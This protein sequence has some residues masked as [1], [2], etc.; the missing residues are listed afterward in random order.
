MPGRGEATRVVGL[1]F[2]SFYTAGSAVREGRAGDLYKLDAVRRFQAVLEEREGIA[3]G[4]HYAPWWNP[5]FYALLFVPLAGMSFHLALWVWLIG[6]VVCGGIACWLLL[7]DAAGGGGVEVAGVGA[8]VN[9]AVDAVHAE[10]DARA[11]L[12]YVIVDSDGGCMVLAG[13]AG[14]AGRDGGGTFV[15]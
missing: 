3:I 4:K 8:G 11:E 6:N 12:V 2:V 10:H 5:P 9:G 1:D 7:Q 15:L 14:M 13:G